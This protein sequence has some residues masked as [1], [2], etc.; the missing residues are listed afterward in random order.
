VIVGLD[1]KPALVWTGNTATGAGGTRYGVCR[2]TQ[3]LTRDGQHTQPI[4]LVWRQDDSGPRH[5]VGAAATVAQAKLVAEA[6][7]R[8]SDCPSKL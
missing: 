2:E 1:T 4:F 7:A 6:S 3:V 8:S 5:R